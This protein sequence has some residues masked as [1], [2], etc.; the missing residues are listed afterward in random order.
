MGGLLHDLLQRR[1][2]GLGNISILYRYHDMSVYI[3]L[4]FG[5]CYIVISIQSIHCY[6]SVTKIS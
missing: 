5:F 1:T 3:M 6:N 4:G 2:V